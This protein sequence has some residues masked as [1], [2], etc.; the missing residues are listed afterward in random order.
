MCI[1]S[2]SALA[3][4]EL[5]A[6]SVTNGV[7][8]S[9]FSQPELIHWQTFDKR[10]LSGF[11]YRPSERFKGK[12]PVIIDIHG[13][14]E[15]QYRPKFLYEDNYLLNELGVAKIYPNVRGSSGY[16]KSFLESRQWGASRG[17]RKGHWCFAGLDQDPT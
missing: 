13:G 4:V 11:L 9:K 2:I 7:D 1:Q 5:W 15:E 12:R 17:R 6:K 16:G 3:K 14:P 10:T 8:T